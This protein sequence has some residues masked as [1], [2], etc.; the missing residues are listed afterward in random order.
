MRRIKLFLHFVDF[1]HIASFLLRLRNALDTRWNPNRML[2][3][4]LEYSKTLSTKVV[5]LVI[6]TIESFNA[7]SRNFS[8]I[9]KPRLVPW[10]NFP[11]NRNHDPLGF[12]FFA[13]SVERYFGS[14]T[15]LNH[16]TYSKPDANYVLTLLTSTASNL[17]DESSCSF[18]FLMCFTT[19]KK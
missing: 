14:N 15:L 6:V 18:I 8:S 17:S 5:C 12:E 11:G 13:S 3:I 16:I 19:C 4:L 7:D 2:E 9:V 10:R 1:D